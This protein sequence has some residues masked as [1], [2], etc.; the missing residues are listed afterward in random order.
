[1]QTQKDLIN[2]NQSISRFVLMYL[3][4]LFSLRFKN[5]L[6]YNESPNKIFAQIFY[7]KGITYQ[8]CH[9]SYG[10]LLSSKNIPRIDSITV[11]LLHI[12]NLIEYF[13]LKHMSFISIDQILDRPSISVSVN[14]IQF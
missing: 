8:E 10:L 1:M 12:V 2:S 13:M 9:Q 11:F 7:N 14:Q 5:S 4:R 6:V 3:K